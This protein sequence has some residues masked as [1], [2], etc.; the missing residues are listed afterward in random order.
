MLLTYA[1]YLTYTAIQKDDDDSEEIYEVM[2]TRSDRRKNIV[3]PLKNMR[4]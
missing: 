1:V 4:L 2:P 3:K